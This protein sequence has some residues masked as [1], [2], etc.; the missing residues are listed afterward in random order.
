MK[1]YM[2]VLTKQKIHYLTEFTELYHTSSYD[3]KWNKEENLLVYS[4]SYY[5]IKL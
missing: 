4:I 2:E 5:W 1:I 3:L